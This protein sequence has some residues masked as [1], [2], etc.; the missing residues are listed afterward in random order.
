MQSFLICQLPRLLHLS[1]TPI[2]FS[3]LLLLSDE[4]GVYFRLLLDA[5]LWKI[6][7]PLGGIFRLNYSLKQPVGQ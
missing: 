4:E 2:P 5:G 3:Y 7:E 1:P 6:G